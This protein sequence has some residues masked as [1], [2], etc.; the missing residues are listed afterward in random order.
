MLT[1]HYLPLLRLAAIT[2]TDTRLID[3]CNDYDPVTSFVLSLSFSLTA[4]TTHYRLTPQHPALAPPEAARQ[5]PDPD[6]RLQL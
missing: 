5:C 6:P 2:P 4:G 1:M 3:L